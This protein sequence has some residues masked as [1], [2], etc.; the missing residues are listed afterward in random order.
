MG[1]ILKSAMVLFIVFSVYFTQDIAAQSTS[2]ARPAN[3]YIHKSG[4]FRIV[5][6]AGFSQILVKDDG[7]LMQ[8]P[9][10]RLILMIDFTDTI[11]DFS[12]QELFEI[13]IKDPAFRENIK[14]RFIKET[15][16]Y[17]CR[18]IAD[19]LTEFLNIP[20]WQFAAEATEKGER[21]AMKVICFFKNRRMFLINLGGKIENFTNNESLIRDSLNTFEVL[22]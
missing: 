17:K 15:P 19:S 11:N 18:V 22:K 21:I 13:N 1:R 3:Y 16:T 4:V 5:P 12:D 9:I 14:K 7:L 8:D 10:K 2:V 6:P 20:A